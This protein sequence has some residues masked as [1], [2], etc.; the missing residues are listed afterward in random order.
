HELN[1]SGKR[2]VPNGAPL[3]FVINRWRKYIHD[4]DGNINR[5]FYEL[6]AFTELRNYVRS[7]DISIVGSRQHKDF[8]EYLISINEWNHS[9]ENGIRLAVSTHADEY[10]AERTKTLLERIATFSKNAHALE[11]VDISGGTLHLQRLDK[12]TP[13]TAKQLS[14]KL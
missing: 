3:S 14:S 9:K 2:K 8:D 10:V 11:G 4:E 12:D 6:A 5:H 7:G 1:E 13:Q